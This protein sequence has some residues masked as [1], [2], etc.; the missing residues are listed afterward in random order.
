MMWKVSWYRRF[1]TE[2][3]KEVTCSGR[4]VE[5]TAR[6]RTARRP[7]NSVTADQISDNVW[8]IDSHLDEFGLLQNLLELRTN[9]MLARIRYIGVLVGVLVFTSEFWASRLLILSPVKALLLML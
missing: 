3:M 1:V 6:L 4:T 5:H 7:N 8:Q 2:E 9:R